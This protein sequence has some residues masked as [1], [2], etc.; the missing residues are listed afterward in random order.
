MKNKPIFNVH[1]LFL[2]SHSSVFAKLKRE[3][4]RV[5]KVTLEDGKTVIK[6]MEKGELK[7]HFRATT[8]STICHPDCADSH[9]V[10]IKN[11]AK[12]FAIETGEAEKIFDEICKKCADDD[13]YT[14]SM[15]K[16]SEF[17]E[18]KLRELKGK[19]KKK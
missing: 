18:K 13:I 8:L 15:T 10:F 17:R 16:V 5:Y 7:Q 2:T 19:F 1:Q 4:C 11:I 3:N 6:L 14:T 12:E 9:P